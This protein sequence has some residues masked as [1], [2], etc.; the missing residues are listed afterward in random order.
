MSEEDL[1]MKPAASNA[2]ALFANRFIFAL[3]VIA[4][5]SA[6]PGPAG[7]D[8]AS[9]AFI[10]ALG[11][12]AVSVI[13]SDMPLASKAADFR[14]MI[15]E[16]FDLTGICRFCARPILACRESGCDHW[17]P[18]L[19]SCAHSSFRYC[20]DDG[21]AARPFS[22]RRAPVFP[23]AR[24]RHQAAAFERDGIWLLAAIDLL[25][26]IEVSTSRPGPDNAAGGTP[27]G[28]QASFRTADQHLGEAATLPSRRQR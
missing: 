25:L 28:K 5:V 13:R 15:H 1:A 11:N 3:S 18:P 14:R 23:H 21:E 20:G 19:W 17:G 27:H 12:Q 2:F 22:R 8:E 16:D 6:A 24:Q 4:A 7:A 10:R 9:T 26:L